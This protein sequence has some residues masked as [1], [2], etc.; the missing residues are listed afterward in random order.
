MD[1]AEAFR[2]PFTAEFFELLLG[3]ISTR[4]VRKNMDKKVLK[5]LEKRRRSWDRSV[6][7]FYEGDFS[8]A[9]LAGAD[10]K[11]AR[12]R[13]PNF[14]HANLSHAD[15]SYT[16]L[17][18]AV[19]TGADLRHANFTA[20]DLFR[21]Y[22]RGND[23]SRASLNGANLMY[24]DLGETNL[25]EAH[26]AGASLQGADLEGA[27]LSGAGLS[28]VD[29]SGANLRGANLNTCVMLGTK[30]ADVDLSEVVGLGTIR[31]GGPS[32]I[33]IDTIYRSKGKIPEIFLRG[34]GVPETFI[35]YMTSLVGQAFEY[36]SC[37]I[38]YSG[39]DQEFADRLHK[40]LQAKGV[41]CWFAPQ[42]VQG[43][44]KL[45]DQID[46]AIRI[47][48]RVLLILSPDSI[49]SEWV[50]TEIANARKR[51]IKEKERVLFPV[52]LVP[53]ETLQD[54]ECFD[55]D[56]GKDSARELREY[57]IPDFSNWGSDTA[58]RSAFER[59]L[60]DL[61]LPG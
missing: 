36:Y 7:Y 49:K 52:R 54:W 6:E 19:F 15:L 58:Y 60:K 3:P 37:F 26:L 13:K 50:R 9:E 35:V 34:A 16:E 43:G 27:D 31:H 38:S 32:T 59:L 5:I 48:Q 10:L 1:I 14:S 40:D 17:T 57:F 44:K 30:L 53:F 45:Y 33:G 51:E 18:H 47:H 25:R 20:A 29:L 28:N 56:T 21:A 8:G 39:K 12:F 61:K 24:A 22:L 41:R 23:L 55:A 4:G 46:E 2:L 42:H 11:W